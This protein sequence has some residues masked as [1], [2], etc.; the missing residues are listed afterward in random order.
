MDKNMK[1]RIIITFLNIV[2]LPLAI[3]F[4]NLNSL[5]AQ[6]YARHIKT[7]LYPVWRATKKTPLKNKKLIRHRDIHKKQ[8]G[9]SGKWGFRDATGK[10][11]IPYKYDG[12]GYFSEGLAPVRIKGVKSQ[13]GNLSNLWGYINTNGKFIIKPKYSDARPFFDGLAW[14]EGSNGK[15]FIDKKGAGFKLYR[16]ITKVLAFSQGYAAVNISRK[17]WGYIDHRGKIVL[18]PGLFSSNWKWA[19]PFRNGLALV[20]WDNYNKQ[21]LINK[22]GKMIMKSC[23]RSHCPRNGFRA[24]RQF[25]EGLAQV[26]SWKTG[27]WGFIDPDLNIVIQPEFTYVGKFSEGLAP[28]SGPLLWWLPVKKNG[29]L[30]WTPYTP[31]EAKKKGI[32]KKD[33]KVKRKWGYINR[34]GEFVIKPKFG[35]AW[36]FTD[37]MARIAMGGGYYPQREGKYGYINKKGTIIIKPRF[38]NAG[39]F[40]NGYAPVKVGGKALS[41]TNG[42]WG[43]IDKKG[44]FFVEPMFDKANAFMNGLALVSFKKGGYYGRRQGVV[45]IN[46]NIILV[47]W[48]SFLPRF[49]AGAWD[50]GY[51]ESLM[52]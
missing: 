15:I 5:E 24:I 38:S 28:A 4:S 35:F 33:V 26:L 17:K 10:L 1:T 25:S 45:D 30:K 6:S 42:A 31:E 23:N 27:G 3:F 14:V 46:G 37:G 39:S 50:N 20:V 9:E 52:H 22:K 12:V 11:V 18:K 16:R 40:Y 48:K 36:P 32:S 7:T 44:K 19:Y 8:A 34:S 21:G 29:K 13:N 43:Y 41:F 47:P 49:I 2:L 51:F